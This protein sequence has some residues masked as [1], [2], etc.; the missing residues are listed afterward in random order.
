MKIHKIYAEDPKYACCGLW[1]DSLYSVPPKATSK[2]KDVTCLR[3]LGKGKPV[4][5][6][7]APKKGLHTSGKEKGIHTA[8]SSKKIPTKTM[9]MFKKVAK[10]RV[11]KLKKAKAKLPPV[12]VDLSPEKE[13]L[14]C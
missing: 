14:S 4:G 9:A 8:T 12:K 10:A 2:L 11:A 13:A 5:K 3:C 6:L 7:K 1:L